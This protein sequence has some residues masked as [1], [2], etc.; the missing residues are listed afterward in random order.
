MPSKE[1]KI[2]VQRRDYDEEGYEQYGGCH[3]MQA[4]PELEQN[5]DDNLGLILKEP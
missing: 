1:K 4:E 2:L 5:H 3:A